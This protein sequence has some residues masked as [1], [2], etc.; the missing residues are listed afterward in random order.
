MPTKSKLGPAEFELQQKIAQCIRQLHQ[1]NVKVY[2]MVPEDL[3]KEAA[4]DE[5]E[6]LPDPVAHHYKARLVKLREDPLHGK[7]PCY[8]GTV[9]D[10]ELKTAKD[11]LTVRMS[12]TATLIDPGF[13]WR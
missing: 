4:K 3:V 11:I 13:K 5:L 1:A 9:A 10:L 6:G 7:W 12:M 2:D 8:L